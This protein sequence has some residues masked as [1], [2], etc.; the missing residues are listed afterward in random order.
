MLDCVMVEVMTCVSM[1]RAFDRKK[2]EEQRFDE[3][4]LDLTNVAIKVNR[5]VASLMPIMMLCL[6]VSS[7]A[8]LWFG[9]IRINNG[10]MQVGALIAFLQYA[11]LILFALLMISFMFKMAP[12]SAES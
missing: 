7:I 11:M 5:M 6:N 1:L 2:Y 4:N 8:I 12:V 3:A 10:Q 9:A